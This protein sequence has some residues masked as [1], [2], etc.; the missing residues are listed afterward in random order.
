MLLN[1]NLLITLI[2][3][4]LILIRINVCNCRWHMSVYQKMS[5]I[6]D[7]SEF[8]SMLQENHEAKLSLHYRE[9]TVLAATNDA[10]K[11]YL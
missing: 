8:Y 3:L 11:R 5:T 2:S 9:V 1:N 6:K 4:L 10:I 7:I